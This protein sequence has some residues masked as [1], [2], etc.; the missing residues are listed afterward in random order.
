V[1]IGARPAGLGG[2]YTAISDDVYGVYYNPAGLAFIQRSEFSAQ[3]SQMYVGLWDKS[4]LGYSFAGLVQPLRFKSDFGTVGF[5][6]LSFNSGSLYRENTMA[7]SYGRDFAPGTNHIF[8]AGLSFKTLSIGYGTDPD[9]YSE[10][11]I[12][13]D[14]NATGAPDMLFKKFGNEKSAFAIDVGMQLRPYANYRVGVAV[15]NANEPA[16]ALNPEDPAK[17][18]KTIALGIAHTGKSFSVAVDYITRQFNSFNDYRLSIAGEQYLAFGLG[19]RAGMVTGTRGLNNLSAGVGFRTPSFQLDYALEYP[20]SGIK[21][22]M[23]N[24]K[25]SLILRFG[26]AVRGEG[27]VSAEVQMELEKTRERLAAANADIVNFKARLE[28]LLKKP[29]KITAPE[30]QPVPSAAGPEEGAGVSTAAQ[31]RKEY[32]G[33]YTAYIK[34][35]D[36]LSFVKRLERIRTI[37][38]KYRGRTE[39]T[40]AEQEYKIL[41]QEQKTQNQMYSDSMSYYDKMALRGIDNKTRIDILKKII[42]KYSP[43]GIDVSGAKEEQNKLK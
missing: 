2:A 28:E 6:W 16:I 42:E 5:S 32:R 24:H 12:D 35:A 14:G 17:L 21:G 13:A 15:L 30:P 4:S 43:F 41:L 9:G 23:G 7:F 3:Y 26:K 33:E 18:A 34:G 37:A 8:S 1:S 31:T 38:G 39:I 22:T 27:A 40:E 11:A 25:V 20:L 36:E 29:Q 10:N 19:L